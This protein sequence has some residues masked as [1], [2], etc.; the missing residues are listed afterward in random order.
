M[1]TLSAKLEFGRLLFLHGTRILI[2]LL[3]LFLAVSKAPGEISLL[4]FGLRL[5]LE[6][7]ILLSIGLV[8]IFIVYQ[9]FVCVVLSHVLIEVIL[10][11]KHFVSS[12]ELISLLQFCLFLLF[13]GRPAGGTLGPTPL[14][15]LD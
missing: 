6:I 10:A 3:N 1:S 14:L 9:E 8:Y 5:N 2:F 13:F 4:S 7:E 11:L 15:A 12:F